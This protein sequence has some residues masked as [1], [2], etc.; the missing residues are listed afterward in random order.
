MRP[1]HKEDV[2][3][4]G[5]IG[6]GTV[7]QTLAKHFLPLGHEVMLSNTRGPA[8]LALD[9][10]KLGAGASAGTPQQ[11]AEQDIVILAVMWKDVQAAFFSVPDWSGRILVD[12]TNRMAGG[13]PMTIVDISGRTSSEIVADL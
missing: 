1:A 6:A 12:A 9:I 8:S 5:I 13:E 11:A 10:M 7:A 4:I 3:Q 2:M